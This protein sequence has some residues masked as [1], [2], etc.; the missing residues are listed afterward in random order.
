MA[1]LLLGRL[2]QKIMYFKLKP[3]HISFTA[4][5]VIALFS[6]NLILLPDQQVLMY[7]SKRLFVCGLICFV[8]ILAL[9]SS[10]FR[11]RIIERYVQC[12]TF[13]R[14]LIAIFFICAL[15][16]DIFGLYPS[17]AIV[18][19]FYFCGFFVLTLAFS[20]GKPA[21]VSF[22][23][24]QLITLLCFISVLIGY[25]VATFIGEG[26]TIRTI[27]SYVNPR[28]LNQIQVWMIIPSLYVVLVS[29]KR[30]SYLFPILNFAMMF[31]LD[32]RG[33][34][35]A[36]F[37][38]LLL[39]MFVDRKQSLKIA[40]ITCI[41]IFTGLA[42]S[43]VLLSPLPS[44]LLHGE[45]S[46]SLLDMRD[47]TQDRIGLWLYAVDMSRFWG[48]GGDGYVC[49]S[50][51]EIRPHN[52]VL[53]ILLNWGAIPAVCY[54][55]LVFIL[56]KQVLQE[57]NYR[58]RIIGLTLLSGLAL[59]LVSSVLDS[60]FSLLLASMFAGW[61]CG[62]RKISLATKEHKLAHRLLIV[63]CLLSVA[64]ISYK[65]YDRIENGFYID[66]I[67]PV[68]RPQFWLGNNCPGKHIDTT[69]KSY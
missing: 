38:G 16:A 12:T 17:K 35:I 62:R 5:T 11:Q 18:L 28:F 41:S 47:T 64:S 60:P 6:L 51:R 32:A 56:L 44:Y 8:A 31:A 69:T 13:V 3:D 46:R 67:E 22:R 15:I 58:Y 40:K 24:I 2:S 7:D 9:V 66:N 27:L 50:I 39:W 45:G 53:K 52:S 68:R 1:T 65:A 55:I 29:K 20:L 26:A 34:A 42:V 25:S 10:A 30:A 43:F 57:K 61:F 14:Y 23:L 59:S 19:Y 48:L 49:T 4:L 21:A 63:V 37:G 36:T 33:L 54:V